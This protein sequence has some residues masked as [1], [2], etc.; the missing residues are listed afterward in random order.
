MGGDLAPEDAIAAHIAAIRELFEE[1]GVLLAGRA[2]T[3]P[4]RV[5]RT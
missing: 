4:V 1:A 2:A 5:S 3:R